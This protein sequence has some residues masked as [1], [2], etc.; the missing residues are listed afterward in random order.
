MLTGLPEGLSA[1]AALQTLDLGGCTGL[2]GLPE[3]I[4]ALTALKK[5]YLY[6][7]ECSGLA[8]LPEV[9]TSKEV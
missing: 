6:L 9:R 3:G 2:R 7:T 1:L 8:G 5:L 4:S